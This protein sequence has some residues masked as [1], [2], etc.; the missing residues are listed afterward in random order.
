VIYTGDLNVAHEEI[1]IRNPASN[2]MSA[3]FS[4]EE[5]AKMSELLN[6]GF[7]DTFR[8]LY[9]EEVKYSW[10]SYRFNSRAK[11]IGWRIDYFLV[12][13]RIM[14]CVKDSA[15]LD[16]ITGSDH[17]PVRLDIQLNEKVV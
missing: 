10:W 8:T 6:S 14:N 17:C 15:V 4:D 13:D 1:D 2:H 11:G 5:R 9:P 12:S 7:S 16:E 3:G